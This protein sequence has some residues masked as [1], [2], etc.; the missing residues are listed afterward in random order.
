ML[1]KFFLERLSLPRQVEFMKKRGI[2]LGTRS[3]NGR[4]VF[5]YMFNELFAE[6]LFENDN[7]EEP[8]ERLIFLAGLDKLNAHLEKET[9]SGY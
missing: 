6:V 4:Q 1:F 9:K 7:P 8:A 2:I 5:I 3:K